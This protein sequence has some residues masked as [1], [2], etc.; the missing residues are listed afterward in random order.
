VK[1]AGVEKRATTLEREGAKGQKHNEM[2]KDGWVFDFVDNH[3]FQFFKSFRICH[4]GYLGE[5]SESKHYCN[6]W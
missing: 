3:W 4:L 6:F 2:T 5:I 1:A